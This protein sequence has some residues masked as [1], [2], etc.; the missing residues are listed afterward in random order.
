M[1][2]FLAEQPILVLALLV[3]LGSALGAIRVAGAYLGPAAVLFVALGLSA[4]G[5]SEGV[6]MEL[7]EILGSFG[8]VLFTYAIGVVSGPSFFGSLRRGWPV[9]LSVVGCLGLA[10]LA[11]GVVGRALGLPAT[12]TAGA[13]AG[14]LTNTP[15]L[16]A[17]SQAA[18]DAQGP[19]LGYS[20]S[21]LWGVI[22]MLLAAAVAL[23]RAGGGGEPTPR[24]A[25]RTIRVERATGVLVADL[26][27][28]HP[29]E[30][31]FSRIR[32]DQ[33]PDLTIVAAPT[34][35][36]GQG[37][38]V[39]VVGPAAVLDA[40][41]AELGHVSSHDL[42]G[43]RTH[44]DSNRVTLSRPALLGLRLVDL[45]LAE[46]FGAQVSRVR[47]GDVDLVATPDFVVQSGDR[48]RVV[49]PRDQMQAIR[50]H[51]GD[52]E[53]GFSDIN[54]IGLALGLTL[55]VALGLVRL[56]LPGGGFSLGSAAGTL[57]VGLVFGKIGRVGPVVTSMATAA[58]HAL[59]SLGMLV[60]LAYAGTKA[61][62]GFGAAVTS[63]MGWRI[64][65]LGFA[66]TTVAAASL[67][68]AGRRLHA[69]PWPQ[70]AGQLGGAQTQPAVLAFANTRTDFDP[71]VGLGYALVYPAAMVAKILLA[72]VLVAVS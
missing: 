40:M 27:A 54:P 53:R 7:P 35:R 14:A 28:K 23:R 67:L 39:S 11:S 62:A 44:L 18:G 41:A 32:H 51:L 36:L 19:A 47:R 16:A 12:V 26:L 31:S 55:G 61:G 59:S 42:I 37:D 21:Y 60:F 30:V 17:A 72:Q 20:I 66:V 71:R 70:L 1:L 34:E 6:T 69:T 58:S 68:L 24:L 3:L 2:T 63:D 4:W 8:L 38:L 29:G 33:N 57:V 43:D 49:A 15:A 50:D 52:S 25:Q 64:A 13:F 9:M 5:A 48:L 22:G 10:A 45:R 56:P 65:L 46:R